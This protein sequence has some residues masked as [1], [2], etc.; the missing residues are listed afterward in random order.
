M[1]WVNRWISVSERLPGR[2]V[3]VAAWV[4]SDPKDE[5]TG[6]PSIAWVRGT[7]DW[8]FEKDGKYTVSHWTPLPFKRPRMTGE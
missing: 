7:G 6:Q 8:G 3:P 1:P 2:W 5:S 4:Y